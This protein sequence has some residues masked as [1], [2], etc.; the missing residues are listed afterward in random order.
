VTLAEASE[1]A[2]AS[3]TV[4]STFRKVRNAPPPLLSR[5]ELDRELEEE[6]ASRSSS[7]SS[8]TAVASWVLDFFELL[9]E[10][11]RLPKRASAVEEEKISPT[12]AAAH[13]RF[14]RDDTVQ[15]LGEALP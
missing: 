10:L 5:E 7:S 11:E 15:P 9:E 14:R 13:S 8:P 4:V 6:D 1:A 3:P 12:A 2:T